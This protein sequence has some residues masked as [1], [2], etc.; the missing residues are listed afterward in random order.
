MRRGDRKVREALI[1]AALGGE[2]TEVQ[3]RQLYALG[4]EAVTL[5]L[6][7]ASRRI[8]ELR[9]DGPGS[10]PATPSGMVPIY[11]KPNTPKRRK[12][13]GARQ[14]HPGTRRQRPVKIDERKTHRLKCCPH[15]SG[16][17]QRCE[18]SRTRITEDIPEVIEP[19]RRPGFV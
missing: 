3:A 8:A 9:A 17:L 4:P 6:L 5:A 15:C 12:K 7:N 16:K 1:A 19:G 14:G 2:L 18:R 13:S 10:S 11:T